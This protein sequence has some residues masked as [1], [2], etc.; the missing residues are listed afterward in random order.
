MNLTMIGSVFG[1]PIEAARLGKLHLDRQLVRP[2]RSR[3]I[4][5]LRSHLPAIAF[6]TIRAYLRAKTRPANSYDARIFRA[7]E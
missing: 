6:A 4:R 5:E 7:D 3:Q 2:T 1:D